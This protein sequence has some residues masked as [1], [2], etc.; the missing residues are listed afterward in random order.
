MCM[1]HILCRCA[2]GLESRNV[3]N[4]EL[5][6]YLRPRVAM[7]IIHVHAIC[8]AT[9]V[10]PLHVRSVWHEQAML[11]VTLELLFTVHNDSCALDTGTQ[12]FFFKCFAVFES[13]S[14]CSRPPGLGALCPVVLSSVE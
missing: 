1:S 9:T 3:C 2:S 14:L 10:H 7:C 13:I 4:C 11:N 6:L 5:S 12:F 8:G